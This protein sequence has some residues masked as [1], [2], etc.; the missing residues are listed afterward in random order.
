MNDD[1][2]DKIALAVVAIIILGAL[3]FAGIAPIY[4]AEAFNKC[5]GGNASYKTAFFT[6]LRVTNCTQ[7]DSKDKQ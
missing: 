7:S 1:L 2:I 3:V 4:E 5:T 6:E